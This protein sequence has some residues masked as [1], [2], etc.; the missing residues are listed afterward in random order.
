MI[1][2]KKLTKKELLELVIIM[3]AQNLPDGMN[4]DITADFDEDGDVEI[5]FVANSDSI[6]LN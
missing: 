2:H 5:Y 4:G 6:N 3:A 1:L